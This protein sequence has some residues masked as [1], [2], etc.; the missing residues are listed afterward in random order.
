MFYLISGCSQKRAITPS[1]SIFTNHISE[2]EYD[3]IVM[4]SSEHPGLNIDAPCPTVLNE[5][6]ILRNQSVG[7]NLSNYRRIVMIDG[8]RLALAMK[9]KLADG[10]SMGPRYRIA[11]SSLE[12]IC[13]LDSSNSFLTSLSK[14]LESTRKNSSSVIEK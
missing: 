6:N 11:Y 7:F 4:K 9:L 5:L 12:N 2:T 3:A 13:T 1:E 8:I 14:A 10:S